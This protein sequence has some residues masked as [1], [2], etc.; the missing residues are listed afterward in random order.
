MKNRTNAMN[1]IF[2]VLIISIAILN[3]LFP[4]YRLLLYVLLYGI[5]N[6][7]LKSIFNNNYYVFFNKLPLCSSIKS[8][9]NETSFFSMLIYTIVN[10]ILFIYWLIRLRY[11]LW[12]PLTGLIVN[13][14]YITSMY[15][16]YNPTKYA[17]EN[18][19][20]VVTY[21]VHSF[22]NEI[23]GFSAK[24][25]AEMMNKEE[26]DVLCFQ[27]YR[28]NGD[29]TEQDLQ[30]TYAK[31]FP[32]SFIPEG[33]SQ[34]IYSRYPIR[35]SQ[36]IEF[37]NTNNG[38]IWADLDVKGMTIRIINVHMQ[39][40]SFDRMRS[41]AAQA[42]GEQ[43]EEQERGIYL[44]YSDNFRENTVRRAG[45][46]EQISSLINATEYPLIVCG[47]FNDP[48]GTFTYETLK[49]GLKDGFQTAGEGYGATY[50]G[51]HHLLR[52]DYLFHSTL[53]EGIKYKVIPYDMSDHNPVYLEVGL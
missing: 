3:V 9:I 25:F 28:G 37:P 7:Q 41:K 51:F 1:I 23:T 24:E 42:R 39:T 20:K 27:E 14:E 19:L 2:I 16:I 38:A 21:N 12:I 15:Q 8:F 49:N 6:S 13:Y 5:V 22:G 4:E 47:D 18:R 30:N 34:A 40:T 10:T 26:T 50:R 46:A 33:L 36:T 11:W 17:N 31:I 32:Y 35:Q 44:G 29:F 43:D 53:L 48:P 45:Q 52:I